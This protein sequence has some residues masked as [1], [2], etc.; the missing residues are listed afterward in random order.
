MRVTHPQEGQHEVGDPQ[1]RPTVNQVGDP[2]RVVVARHELGID[3]DWGLLVPQ[4]AGGGALDDVAQVVGDAAG[5]A[6]GAAIGSF[7]ATFSTTET[8]L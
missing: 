7:S 6:P 1:P 3:V 2:S 4:P 8:F 5:P